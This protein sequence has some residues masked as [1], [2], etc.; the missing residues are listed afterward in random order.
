ML[1][2]SIAT[3]EFGTR[4]I[5]KVKAQGAD[6]VKSLMKLGQDVGAP[7]PAPMAPAPTAPPA[8]ATAPATEESAV[9][10]E[11]TSGDPKQTAL[12]LAEK[13]RD[14]SSDLV[15]AVRTLS[16]EENEMGDVGTVTPEMG[17]TASGEY[18]TSSLNAFR[19]ELNGTLSHAMKEAVAELSD[20]EQE[21][22]MIQICMK[23]VQ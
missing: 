1:Y 6:K 5:E 17:T 23:K 4:L 18:S 8:D 20:H 10:S 21:L 14:I 16:G 9:P 13:V 22:D 7:A 3:R 2:D 19:K 15:E 12:D 11:N